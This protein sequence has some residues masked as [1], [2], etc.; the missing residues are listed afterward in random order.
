[1]FLSSSIFR[2]G[3]FGLRDHLQPKNRGMLT[4]IHAHYLNFLQSVTETEYQDGKRP[5]GR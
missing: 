4:H 5:L 3:T 2:C 1:M